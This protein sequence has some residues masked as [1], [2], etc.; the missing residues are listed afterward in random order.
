MILR[1]KIQCRRILTVYIG[2]YEKKGGK[3]IKYF[4]LSFLF[5]ERKRGEG[6]KRKKS[7]EAEVYA[8]GQYMTE[9]V[10]FNS[11]RLMSSRKFLYKYSYS[12]FTLKAKGKLVDPPQELKYKT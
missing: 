4:Q 5:L 1:K 3:N 10:R 2:W 9:G 7:G 8:E 6:K 12:R 11:L